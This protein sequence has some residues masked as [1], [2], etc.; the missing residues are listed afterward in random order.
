MGKMARDLDEHLRGR[1]CRVVSNDGEVYVG[2][3]DRID[4]PDRHVLLRDAH[5]PASDGDVG[6]V[7]VAHADTVAELEKDSR[8]E[9]LRLDRLQP[10]PYAVSEWDVDDNRGY[11]ADVLEEGDVG[12][13]PVVRP[14]DDDG[15]LDHPGYDGLEIVAGHKRLW[16]CE[17]AGID[18]HPVEVVDYDDWQA[19]LRFILDHYPDPEGGPTRG[20]YSDDQLRES[21]DALVERWGEKALDFPT[22]ASHLDR[23]GLQI[24][25][26]DLVD[27]P[28]ITNSSGSGQETVASKSDPQDDVADDVLPEF[29]EA[30]GNDGHEKSDEDNAVARTNGGAADHDNGDDGDT[31][32]DLEDT[33][34]AGD[35]EIPDVSTPKPGRD[36]QTDVDGEEIGIFTAASYGIA[37]SGVEEYFDADRVSVVD[38]PY[39][40]DLI[41]GEQ[42][43][44]PNYSVS[45]NC[46]QLGKPGQRVV[47]ADDGDDVRAID[48]GDHVQLKL[49]DGDTVDGDEDTGDSRKDESTDQPEDHRVGDPIEEDTDEERVWCGVCGTPAADGE[50]LAEHHDDEDHDGDVIPLDHEP[51]ERELVQDDGADDDAVASR[52][53][54]DVTTEDVHRVVDEHG[55]NGFIGD[56]AEDLELDR[57]ACRTVLLRLGRYSDVIDA[58]GP[59]R[60]ERGA[61]S[62]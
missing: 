44:A 18:T 1:R 21:L 54:E 31:D 52:L 60:S 28:A 57:S 29:E 25:G 51:E 19:A 49:V 14:I 50:D 10:S 16:V 34:S 22:V 59:R 56:I 24:R 12:S 40:A 4:Y 32:D 20:D 8:I 2:W 6:E 23:L 42:G 38:Q 13:Y 46:I 37:L 17:Q 45:S 41:P 7:F 47:G 43:D 11:I 3:V 53:P 30:V 35:E 58:A 62:A 36:D 48:A 39:G 15:N 55:P 27:K 26:L 33:D 9:P 5:A 61:D